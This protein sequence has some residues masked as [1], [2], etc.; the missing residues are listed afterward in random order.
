MTGWMTDV[1]RALNEAQVRYLV[2][3]GVAVV[4]HGYT[5]FT[6]DLDLVIDLESD[7]AAKAVEALSA[8]GFQPKVPVPFSDFAESAKRAEWRDTKNMLVFQ[9]WHASQHEARIDL[10]ISEPFEFEKEFA[11]APLV[12]LENVETRV[13]GLEALIALK[14]AAGRPQDLADVA[15]LR[16]LRD[17]GENADN[18][19]DG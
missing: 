16:E 18:R 14:E 11:Q 19:L 2:V 15:I 13:L 10:F 6:K 17:A 5:R 8:I 1:L 3:G 4:L 9:V 7:N 12:A